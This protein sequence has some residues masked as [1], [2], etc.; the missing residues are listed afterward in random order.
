MRKDEQLIEDFVA[1]FEILDEMRADGFDA[2]AMGLAVGEPDAYGHR[3]WKPI[4]VK[5]DRACLGPIYAKIPSRFPPL[6][7]YLV[8]SYRWAEVELGSFRLVAN[9]PGPDL[10]G[11]F[12]EMTKD[13]FLSTHLLRSG[14]VPFGK[15]QGADYDPVCFD[16]SARKQNGEYR[17]VKLDHEQIL[18]FSRIKVV[19]ELASTFRELVRLTIER[20]RKV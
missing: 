15:G 12:G 7:E 13:D 16:L 11:L 2:P 18:C 8:L 4:H 9:P 3:R 14:F 10:L 20:A 5:A 19:A 1:C 6:F 17:I